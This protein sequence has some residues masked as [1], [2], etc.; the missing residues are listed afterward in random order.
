METATHNGHQTN[1]RVTI[2]EQTEPAPPP[3]P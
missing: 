1:G 2:D 3:H